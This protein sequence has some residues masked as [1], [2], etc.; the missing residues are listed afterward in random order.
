MTLLFLSLYKCKTSLCNP[1]LLF[2]PPWFKTRSTT[3]WTCGFAKISTSWILI[4]LTSVEDKI[5]NGTRSTVQYCTRLIQTDCIHVAGNEAPIVLC[6]WCRQYGVV[7]CI[8]N[9]L[10]YISTRAPILDVRQSNTN[11]VCSSPVCSSDY[12]IVSLLLSAFWNCALARHFAGHMPSQSN[13]D[14]P[15]NRTGPSFYCKYGN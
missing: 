15:V 11:T 10:Y 14:A 2:L 12:T 6:T 4:A 9:A 7:A 13:N 5:L 8:G 1:S 3:K